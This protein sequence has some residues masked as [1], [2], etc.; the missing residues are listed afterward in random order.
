MRNCQGYCRLPKPLAVL[1]DWD[2][3]IID[4]L[5]LINAAHNHLLEIHGK[6]LIGRSQSKKLTAHDPQTII[7]TLIGTT[8]ES[9]VAEGLTTF[10]QYVRKRHLDHFGRTD[11]GYTGLVDGAGELVEAIRSNDIPMG[12][13]TN[14]NHDILKAEIA[15]LRW[16][17]WFK[18][19]VGPGDAYRNKPYPDPVFLALNIMGIEPGREVAFIGD[20]YG[21]IECAN[22]AGLTSIL[23]EVEPYPENQSQPA[24][25]YPNCFFALKALMTP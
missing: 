17:D 12:I 3:T 11:N 14:K 8:D 18:A 15:H 16:D 20:T 2:G 4:S 25:R 13:V 9:A 10:R 23:I 6:P 1:M 19:L 5:P 24:L 22:A 7:G 21:D